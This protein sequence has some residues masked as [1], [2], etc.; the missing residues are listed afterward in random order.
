M[1]FRWSMCWNATCLRCK[2]FFTPTCTERVLFWR[3]DPRR[4]KRFVLK[5]NHVLAFKMFSLIWMRFVLI[6]NV[7]SNLFQYS[8]L[9]WMPYE[10]VL[11]MCDTMI[12]PFWLQSFVLKITNLMII[13]FNLEAIVTRAKIDFLSDFAFLV[14]TKSFH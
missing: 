1:C 10:N 8:I 9:W 12:S 7:Q 11:K 5:T 14:L 2:G 13:F 3:M 6:I 4:T